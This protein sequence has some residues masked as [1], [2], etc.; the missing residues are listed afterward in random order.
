[1][2]IKD[3][4]KENRPRERFLKAGASGLSDAELLAV[5]LQTGTRD[6]NVIDMSN[7]LISK[8]GLDK[9]SD[10]SLKELQEIK[11][12]G[13][14]KAMQIKALFE[15]NKRHAISKRE[16]KPIKCARDVYDY[17]LPLLSGKDREHFMILHLD[18]KNKVIKDEIISI[19]TL[20]ASLVHPR[21]VFKS[22][23]KESANAIVLVHNHPSGDCGASLE[24]KEITEKLIAAGEVLKIK[25]LDHVIIGRESYWSWKEEK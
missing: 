12:I 21:E 18:A 4:S 16:E 25:I 24:D 6:E 19:G 22:A 2:R 5:I 3:I 8:Y 15:F 17:A 14:A 23:I 1:M 20:N 9:L 7:R 10:L 13:P 11:G